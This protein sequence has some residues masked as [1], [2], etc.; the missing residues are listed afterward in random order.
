[1]D[2]SNFVSVLAILRVR[3]YVL[4]QADPT[5]SNIMLEYFPNLSDHPDIKFLEA[6][7]RLG[8]YHTYINAGQQELAYQQLAEI[9]KCL[10]DAPERENSELKWLVKFYRASAVTD[11][12]RNAKVDSDGKLAKYD[13]LAHEARTHNCPEFQLKALSAIVVILLISERY[14]D[15]LRRENELLQQ[16]TTCGQP[17]AF[18][19]A[20][21]R[22]I[23]ENLPPPE[24]PRA[25]KLATD[26]QTMMDGVDWRHNSEV[27]GSGPIGVG[28]GTI[29]WIGIAE[30][31]VGIQE[32]WRAKTAVLAHRLVEEEKLSGISIDEGNLSR[33]L[34]RLLESDR[35]RV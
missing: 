34:R 31:L 19:R 20:H 35:Q 26:L 29:V 22:G 12:N 2:S 11:M 32:M 7:T 6:R 25:E 17:A 5:F 8:L 13:A 1:M 24:H 14:D 18:W 10:Q 9:D 28:L 21:L 30:M 16:A 3:N 4:G 27:E 23:P 15:F 33:E